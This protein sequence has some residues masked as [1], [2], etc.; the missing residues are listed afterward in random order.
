[1]NQSALTYPRVQG[2]EP[3]VR[4]RGVGLPG[5]GL[6]LHGEGHVDVRSGPSHR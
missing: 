5:D 4:Q 3:R 6:Q 2:R 1:M